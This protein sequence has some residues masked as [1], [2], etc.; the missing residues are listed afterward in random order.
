MKGV[1]PSTMDTFHIAYVLW[2]STKQL[3]LLSASW[4]FL[5]WFTLHHWLWRLHVPP[6]GLLIFNDLHFVYLTRHNSSYLQLR[7]PQILL[8]IFCFNY[9][10]LLHYKLSDW[11]STDINFHYS[12]NFDRLKDKYSN[13][14]GRPVLKH[15]LSWPD[16][17][18]WDRVFEPF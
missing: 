15:E 8:T 17:K 13:H 10:K 5:A 7:E 11:A 2:A 14:S 9:G 1:H 6:T 4:K 12:K 3:C 16:G 18:Q